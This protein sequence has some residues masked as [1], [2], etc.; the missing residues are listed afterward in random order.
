MAIHAMVDIETLGTKPNSV[1]FP[2]PELPVI[3]TDSPET[4]SKLMFSN[5]VITSSP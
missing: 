5:I 1:V 3:A 2:E 4:T